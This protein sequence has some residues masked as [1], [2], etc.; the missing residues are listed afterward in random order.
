M[1][2][3]RRGLGKSVFPA[4]IV[5]SCLVLFFVSQYN[6]LL[7]HTFAEVFTAVIACGIFAIAWSSRRYIDNDF[8]L[9]LGL[10]YFFVGCL[11][12]IHVLSYKGMGVFP[13][14]D[15]N[16]PTQLW[17]IARYFEA[18]MFLLA[19][20]FLK[21]S[22]K[23][24]FEA[25]TRK[26]ELIFLS[27]G[28][29]FTLLILS[30][31]YW[32]TFPAM[33]VEGMGLTVSKKI[34]EYIISSIL[35]V[36]IIIL[37]KKR[38]ALDS[39]MVNLLS[40][41]LMVKIASEISFTGYAGVYDFSNVLGHLFKFISF[42]ILYKA[43][44]EMGL[45]NPYR[46]L[47]L[48]LKKNQKSLHSLARFPEE[49]PNPVMR[50][51]SDG[52]LKYAN[53]PA[54]R[55]LSV[56]GWKGNETIP[57]VFVKAS[58][59]I[60]QNEQHKN[61]E[62]TT[63]DG[64]TYHFTLSPNGSDYTVNIYGADITE[65]R[66]AQR[67]LIETQKE[68]NRRIEEHLSEAY[69]HLGIANRKISLLLE[70]EE[71]SREKK[72]KEGIISHIVTLVKSASHAR[73]VLLYRYEGEGRFSLILGKDTNKTKMENLQ[74]VSLAQAPFLKSLIDE[75]K[76][77][78]LPCAHSDP[79]CFNHDN[80]INYFAVLPLMKGKFFSGFLFLGFEKRSS[81]EAQ[82]LEFL[83]IFSVHA[84]SALSRLRAI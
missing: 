1:L 30:V 11:D 70:L 84:S 26:A 28:A 57:D 40:M 14:Y 38:A 24:D 32:K 72:N 37:F 79:G 74:N 55:F 12:L 62:I 63:P 9:I 83:D 82:E 76:R 64:R 27:Y 17:I 47:F 41:A 21:K 60:F 43:V 68:L 81:M 10:G 71:H 61:L 13:D 5:I 15:A 34:S 8:L 42:M 3:M 33:Y 16:L 36:S 45:M 77:I 6:Y 73:L 59:I 29:I 67:K 39:K 7:F 54:F 51:F 35:L 48:D 65:A 25:P 18:L 58:K 19:F 46:F 50:I 66:M 53:G 22:V 75:K 20:L 4:V 56:M 44:V 2:S 78:N 69:E 80:D 49:N 52:Q 31:F 23:L